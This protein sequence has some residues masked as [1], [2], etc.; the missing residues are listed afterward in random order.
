MIAL[1][2]FKAILLV[3]NRDIGGRHFAVLAER[4]AP[5]G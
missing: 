3:G 5:G 4:S 1:V 2:G